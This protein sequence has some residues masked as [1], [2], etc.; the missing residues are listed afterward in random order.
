MKAYFLKLGFPSTAFKGKAISNG[1]KNQ[2]YIPN[3]LA[4]KTA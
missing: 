2:A 1:V 4:K 3:L